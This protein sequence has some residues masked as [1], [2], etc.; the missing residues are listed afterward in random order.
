MISATTRSRRSGARV[1]APC[2]TQL[3]SW[4]TDAAPARYAVSS[5]PKT[6]SHRAI[7]SRRSPGIPGLAATMPWD[8]MPPTLNRGTVPVIAQIEVRHPLGEDV[9]RTGARVVGQVLLDRGRERRP[10]VE[11]EAAE[12]QH[13]LVPEVA[14][15]Q[16]GV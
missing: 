13:R 12:P 11:R 7:R 4:P 15:E 2:A 1:P 8:A 5:R 3:A 6:M 10:R 16:Q 14:G 9:Q